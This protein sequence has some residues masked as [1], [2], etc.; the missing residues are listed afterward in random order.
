MHFRT[1]FSVRRVTVTPR[2]PRLPCWPRP[3]MPT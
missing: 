1:S 2:R 3:A